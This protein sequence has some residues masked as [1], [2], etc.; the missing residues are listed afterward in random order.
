[1]Q[2]FVVCS[3]SS[4]EP[5]RLYH[6]HICE[7]IQI[8]FDSK[9]KSAAVH[10]IKLKKV[11][12]QTWVINV[13]ILRYFDYYCVNSLRPGDRNLTIIASGIKAVPGRHQA[14]IWTNA[15]ILLIGPL[16][17]NFSDQSK[18]YVFIHENAFENIVWKW[19]H[20]VPASM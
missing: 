18:L 6:L 17:T 8:R 12:K 4:P 15:G 1:M 16:Q 11:A 2:Y 7:Q 14:I 13:G 5:V 3:K 9:Y 19:D 20:F 10:G